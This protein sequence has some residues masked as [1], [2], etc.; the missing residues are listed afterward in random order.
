MRIRFEVAFLVLLLGGALTNCLPVSS[1]VGA[2]QASDNVRIYGLVNKPLNLTRA[3]LFSFP[4]VSEVARL[5]CVMGTPNVVYNWSGI[6][7]FY[8][9]TLTEIKP[10]AYKVVTRGSDG[11]E[12]DLLVEEALQPSTILA[13][14]ANGTDLPVINGIQGSFRL[15]VPCKWGYKWVGD[16][17]EIEVVN[18]DYK[19]TYESSGWTDAGDIP[20]CGPLPTTTRPF[21]TLHLPYGNRTF[22]IEI[23]TNVSIDAFTFDYFQKEL[24]ANVTVPLGTTGF[25]DFVLLQ[26]FLKGPYNVTLDDNKI[27][28]VEADVIQRS[29][30]Y[31]PIGQGNHTIRIFGTEFF[32][33]IPEIAVEYNGTVHVGQTV[34]FNASKSVDYGEI[35]SYEWNFGDGIDGTGEVI[36]YSYGK[37][38]I[39]EVRLNATN[40]EG[41]SSFVTL[42]VIVERPP[43]SILPTVKLFLLAV[44]VLLILIFGIL[45]RNRRS[46]TEDVPAVV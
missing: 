5:E 17:K 7:L 2:F 22:E 24:E 23:F 12:S 43:E 28:A 37:E 35:V 13:L 4:M 44:L 25:A 41:I 26:D 6:P 20:D 27:D 16:V 32:G 9:L 34:I 38:G 45:L 11:F 46:E 36:Q 21:E 31:L 19:G 1:L 33:H 39:Y 14:G 3:E 10:E 29:Y 8:L 30:L 40:N 15:V 42:P 18:T